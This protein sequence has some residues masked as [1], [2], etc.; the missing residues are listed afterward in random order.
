MKLK[1]LG[2]F[3]LAIKE[4]KNDKNNAVAHLF[5]NSISENKNGTLADAIFTIKETYAT[6]DASTTAS[7]NLLVGFKPSYTATAVQKLIDAGAVKVAK[8]HCDELALGGTGLYSN[9]GLIVNPLDSSRLVGG[10]SSGSAATFTNNISFALGSDTGDSVRLPASY[11]GI[12][13]FKPSYG[14]ISRYGLFAYSSSLDTVSYFT[15]NVNDTFVIAKTLFGQDNKDFTSKDIYLGNEIEARKPKKIAL[16]NVES[17]LEKNVKKQYQFLREKFSQHQIDFDYIDI[18]KDLLDLVKIVYE[19]ISFSEASSNLANLN[20]V[21]FG[22]RE[23]GETWSEIMKNTRSKGLGYMIQRRLTLGAYFLHQ[24]NQKEMFV[25]AQKI[26][27]LI[28]N[29]WDN[30]HNNY[31]LVVFP[32]SAN[33]APLIGI[34]LNKSF[35]YMDS[36][37]TTANLAGNPSITI[38]W[39]KVNNLPVN[40]ALESKIYEDDRLLSHALWMEEK[41]K[42]WG[43]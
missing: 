36:I 23:S 27:R 24:D 34:E 3:N 25:K 13:G 40:I 22:Q 12:L 10:S 15:H 28:K 5:E 16:L 9:N 43:I 35:G 20:G 19:I 7:S 29:Y 30:L 26:R 4:L 37:L 21:A 14:A 39:I 42:E 38:P 33:V 32:A 17:N 41:F 6:E 18:N 8:V 11:N 31:D 2:D 1:V